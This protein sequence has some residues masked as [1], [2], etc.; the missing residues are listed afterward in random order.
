ML[1]GIETGHEPRFDFPPGGRPP[2]L[3]YMIA[4]MPRTGSSYLSH[5]LW[6][7]GCL[8]APLEYLNFEPAGPFG[9]GNGFAPAQRGTH[10]G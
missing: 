8:G 6:G 3:F 1:A 7:T 2:E 5:L 4:T 9:F 10:F